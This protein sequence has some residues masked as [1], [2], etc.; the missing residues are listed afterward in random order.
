MF[1]DDVW[2]IGIKLLDEIGAE[3]I[4]WGSDFPHPDGVWPDSSEFIER[5][6]GHL[7]D[8]VRQ[9]IVR[10]NAGTLYGLIR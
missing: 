4:M 5:E 7:P 9:K 3:T 10:E 2:R 6:L 8:A 1:G